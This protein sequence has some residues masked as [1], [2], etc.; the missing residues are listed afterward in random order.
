MRNNPVV[1]LVLVNVLVIGFYGV[2]AF[3]DLN[4]RTYSINSH[5]TTRV[6][7]VEYGVLSYRPTYQYY[8][9][10]QD[11]VMVTQGSWTFDFFQFAI[12]VMAIVDIRWFYVN[13]Q[14]LK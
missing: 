1:L 10:G 8:D 11:Q 5:S 7:S 4:T 12:L 6:V 13:K 3:S 2:L 14:K 9:R